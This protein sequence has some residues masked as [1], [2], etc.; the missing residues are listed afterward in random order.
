MNHYPWELVAL[1]SLA[2]LLYAIHV[3]FTRKGKRVML[4]DTENIPTLSRVQTTQRRKM[5]DTRPK[6]TRWLQNHC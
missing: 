5:I 6:V 1:L 2:F 4:E 3:L